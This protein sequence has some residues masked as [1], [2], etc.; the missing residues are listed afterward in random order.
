MIQMKREMMTKKFLAGIVIMFFLC[1][2]FTQATSW[3]GVGVKPDKWILNHGGT[4]IRFE[5]VN[6]NG[7]KK[8][9][10]AVMYNKKGKYVEAEWGTQGLF[11]DA[12]DGVYVIKAKRGDSIDYMVKDQREDG[13]TFAKIKLTAHPGETI[14][15][16]FDYK[17]KK[18]K[19][20]TDYVEPTK[21]A[22]TNVAPITQ[23]KTQNLEDVQQ[24]NVLGPQL[25]DNE[26]SDNGAAETDDVDE[27]NSL[28]ETA[29]DF[30]HPDVIAKEPEK[31]T[32]AEPALKEQ[33]SDSAK[34]ESGIFKKFFQVVF[35]WFSRIF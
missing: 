18:A 3:W 24:E 10:K 31:Q 14:K 13:K 16:K 11:D 9:Y 22:A 8:E 32:S 25:S 2:H 4:L 34:E 29:E 19:M 30:I 21:K 28:F 27:K 23:E 35:S 33:D 17:K 7:S 1:P 12:K 6:Y 20:T 5:I 15:I 26:V